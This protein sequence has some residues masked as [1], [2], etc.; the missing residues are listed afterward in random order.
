MLLLSNNMLKLIF[1][2]KKKLKHM[3]SLLISF[4]FTITFSIVAL[5]IS[6]ID[7]DNNK[8]LNKWKQHAS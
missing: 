2:Y 4:I 7:I 5:S 3:L 6:V 1:L 8:L